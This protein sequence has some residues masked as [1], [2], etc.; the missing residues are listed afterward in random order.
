MSEIAA[1][2]GVGRTT[3][4][5]NF[6]TRMDLASAL[7][8]QSMMQFRALAAEQRGARGDLEALIDLKLSFYI[9]NAGVAEAV[10]RECGDVAAF[11]AYRREVAQLLLT[12][13]RREGG[14]RADLTVEACLVMQQAIAGAMLAGR[15]RA[16]RVARAALVKTLLLDGLYERVDVTGMVGRSAAP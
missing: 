1:A 16:D 14:M 12:A 6:P 11:Q 13:A 5:R 8:E 7:F 15:S 10:Q 9:Q 4:I 2:A 3:L